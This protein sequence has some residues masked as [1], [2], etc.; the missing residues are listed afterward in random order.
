MDRRNATGRVF[1]RGRKLPRHR[2]RVTMAGMSARQATLF[3]EPAKSH[4]TRFAI[5]RVPAQCSTFRAGSI[6]VRFLAPPY[7]DPSPILALTLPFAKFALRLY[8]LAHKNLI[9]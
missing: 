6:V 4:L 1:S 5:F 7:S 9:A 2:H 3:I 8:P